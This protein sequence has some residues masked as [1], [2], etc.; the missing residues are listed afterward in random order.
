MRKLAFGYSTRCNIRC[1]HCVAS[2]E[3]PDNRK[4]EFERAQ[5]IIAELGR[6]GVGGLSFS[7]GEP[8][9]DPEEIV[10]LVEL[11]REHGIYSRVV[12]NCFWA[13]SAEE[14]D[15]LVAELHR[16][17][18]C[19]LRLSYSRWHQKNIDRHNVLRA[20]RS[21]EKIGL[22]YFIS[23]VTDFAAEDD[24][25]EQFLREH[26]L[27]FFP[28]PLIYAGRAE[29]FPRRNIVTD[30]QAN[31]CAMNP[32]LS[33]DLDMYACCDAGSRFLHTNIF[34]L[35]NLG[36]T[37]AEQL[38]IKSETDP[39]FRLIRTMGLTDIASY[40]GIKGR[41]IIT[42]S[43]CELC[44]RLF[45]SPETVKRLRAEVAQLAVWRR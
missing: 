20:A 23:F 24:P 41:E 34:Y 10:E 26:G 5:A 22:D 16:R 36:D 33:P 37:T 11:C 4:M 17:G 32:Y 12:S 19:Q 13:R 14:S 45:D 8:L 44:R 28:E 42:Y 40:A 18:L 30:Y 27:I 7:A 38:F 2:D 35:G 6:A 25:Y 3:T 1:A 29:S 31:C 43:K 21:C 15:L 9:L 39:L